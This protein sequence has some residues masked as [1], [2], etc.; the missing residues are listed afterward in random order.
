M[1]S[2]EL[3]RYL[4]FTP[5]DVDPTLQGFGKLVFGSAAPAPAVSS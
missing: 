1:R 4:N 3:A 5:Q 2:A